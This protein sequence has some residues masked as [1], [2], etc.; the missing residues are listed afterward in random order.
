MDVFRDIGPPLGCEAQV[1][2]QNSVGQRGGN[3]GTHV[4]HSIFRSG[5]SG[6]LRNRQE[7]VWEIRLEMDQGLHG[8]RSDDEPIEEDP[9]DEQE[10][11]EQFYEV[12]VRCSHP[13]NHKAG[14]RI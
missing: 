12:Y 11:A 5:H 3:L 7:N 13:P 9:E 1:E 10:K 2:A 6:E 14:L 8:G 4:R